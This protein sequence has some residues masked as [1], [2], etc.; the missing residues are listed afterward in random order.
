MCSSQ[1]D[2]VDQTVGRAA[3]EEPRCAAVAPPSPDPAE[4][5]GRRAE[6]R[7]EFIAPAT[8][9]GRRRPLRQSVGRSLLKGSVAVALVAGMV[10]AAP[11]GIAS[12]KPVRAS[13]TPVSLG[14]AA[15]FGAL[16]QTAV[17][18]MNET[19]ITGDLGVSPGSSVV[20]FPPGTVSGTIHANDATAAQAMTDAVAAYNNAAGQTP[21][22][23]VPAQLGGT[24]KAPGVYNSSTG[25]FSISGTLTLDA[26]GDPDAVFI[27]QASTLTTANVSNINL[28]RG[29]QADNVF[30]QL[31]NNATLGTYCT[32]RGNVL[33]QNAV[34][35]NTGAAIFGRVF[36]L[37]GTISAQGTGGIPATRVTVPNDPPTTTTLVSSLNPAWQGDPVTF[38]AT[39]QANSGSVIPA[40]EVVFKDGSTIV[41]STFVN[42]SGV[43]TFTTAGLSPGQHTI[44]AVYLGG[45]TFDNEAL[46][47]FAPST[48]PAL[49]QTVSDSL[50]NK[51]AIPATAS[52]PDSQPV[53]LGVKFKSSTA[54]TATGVR[55]YKGP[56]NTGTHTGSLW[57]SSGQLLTSVTFANETPSGWQQANFGTPV[58][59]TANTTYVIS[60]HAPAGAYSTTRP[61]FATQYT[62]GPLTALSDGAGGG[63]GVYTYGATSTFP[64]ASYQATNYWVDVIFAPSDSLWNK[65]ATPATASQPDSQPVTLGVKFNTS[66]AGTATGVR[67]YK[68]PQNTGTHTGSLWTSSGQHL[69]TATFANETPSGW[70]QA[71]FGTPVALT[72][73][74]TY[75]ISYHAPAGAY[76]T[77]RPY[78]ATQYTNGPLTALSD[79]A[80]GGNGVYTYG[81]TNTFPTTSYQATNYWV[82]VIFHS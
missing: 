42:P 41:R 1:S 79:G 28:L 68:A 38:T 2:A 48:S 66:T 15:P 9:A 31:S 62:N 53:T 11:A 29:A 12:A 8:G 71:N 32:F 80:G 13:A 3:P 75:I 7:R 45:D 51:T 60:Y 47:H 27:F 50:W 10:A 55:F 52:Q 21:D 63:N 58:A 4:A 81:A 35:I 19:S 14:A 37:I 56:Q 17:S 67:F 46:I 69:T 64:T 76:S 30:W 65:T 23:T 57:T 73:N 20:G 5:S 61:Y 22:A 36:A 26:Q 39:V 43:A 16:A 49:S 72:A 54:G 77:T 82:D 40:G 59:L 44:T 18:N 24:T 25:S 78:F 6:Y 34:T 70:Q 74:T 33:T